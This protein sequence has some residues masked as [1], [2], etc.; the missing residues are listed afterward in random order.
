MK[1]KLE[2]A[3]QLFQNEII[4][5]LEHPDPLLNKDQQIG[6]MNGL[7]Q[8]RCLLRAAES[9]FEGVSAPRAFVECE[10]GYILNLCPTC[11][12]DK[13]RAAE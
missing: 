1:M 7:R 12:P 9:M 10:H 13:S 4:W 11:F 6:F 5:C 3:T 8:A 2:E